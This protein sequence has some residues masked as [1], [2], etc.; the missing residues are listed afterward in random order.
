MLDA[1]IRRFVG[2]FGGFFPAAATP[3]TTRARATTIKAQAVRRTTTGFLLEDGSR[4]SRFAI[5][6]LEAVRLRL[7]RTI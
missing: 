3:V 2:P 6:S 1:V 4:D 5:R 7:W